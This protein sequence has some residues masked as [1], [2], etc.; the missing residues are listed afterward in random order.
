MREINFNYLLAS[1][2]IL[3]FTGPVLREYTSVDHP[4]LL[5]MAFITALILG[6]VSLTGDRR[7][8]LTGL[9]VASSALVCAT[10]SIFSDLALFRYLMFGA[11]FVFFLL[12]IKYSARHVFLAGAVDLNKIVGAVCIFLLLAFLWAILFQFLEALTPGSFNGMMSGLEQGHFDR[13]VYFSLVTLTTLGYGDI[14]P[15]TSLAG[16]LVTLEA[17][18][19][20]FYIAILVAALVGDFMA[21]RK[22]DN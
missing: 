4:E 14:S 7:E 19:G 21:T 3:M 10:V 8:F 18:V 13:F 6:V 16:I 22:T 9:A 11:G 15:K 2:I 12:A 1:L 5:E 20:V 17:V